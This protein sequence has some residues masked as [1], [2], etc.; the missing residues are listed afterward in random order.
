[1]LARTVFSL[2]AFCLVACSVPLQAE[3]HRFTPTQFYNTWSAA[4]PPALRIKP[5]DRVITRTIDASGM[6][7]NG[8]MAG[9]G[10]NPQ[11]G[12]FYIVVSKIRKTLLQRR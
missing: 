1:M 10:P 4:H 3:T 5:G 8:K 12:P 11:T 2:I 6:D 9:V 7:W